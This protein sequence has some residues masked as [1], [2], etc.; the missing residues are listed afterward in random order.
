MFRH[1][2]CFS[3][4]TDTPRGSN[5]AGGKGNYII[6]IYVTGMKIRLRKRQRG[7]DALI[8]FGVLVWMLADVQTNG[9]NSNVHAQWFSH[10]K[11]R[12]DDHDVMK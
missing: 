8:V 2:I 11:I 10:W 5:E 12:A 6:Y 3:H 7:L 1:H 9:G 4:F